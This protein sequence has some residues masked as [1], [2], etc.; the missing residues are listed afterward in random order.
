MDDDKR[1][2][3]SIR[4][5]KSIGVVIED[6]TALARFHG[7][8]ADLSATGMRL[9][10]NSYLP[11]SARY[12]FEFKRTPPLIVRGEVRWV[13]AFDGDT[14]ACG[15]LFVDLTDEQRHALLSFLELERRR[16]LAR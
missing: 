16:V 9:L 10:S 4:L 2:A 15:V 12:A 8:V 7:K 3:P 11:V 5:R 6:K 14:F 13:R 1:A